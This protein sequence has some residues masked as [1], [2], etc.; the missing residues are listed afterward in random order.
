MWIFTQVW[1]LFS[2]HL[3]LLIKNSVIIFQTQLP[4]VKKRDEPSDTLLETLEFISGHVGRALAVVI[5][6]EALMPD[7]GFSMATPEPWLS[8]L[9]GPHAGY[10]ARDCGFAA[11]CFVVKEN[12]ELGVECFPFASLLRVRL[13]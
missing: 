12:D 13:H 5:D 2:K 8:L 11:A 3:Y 1:P 4:S 10:Q 6:P 7:K 9:R